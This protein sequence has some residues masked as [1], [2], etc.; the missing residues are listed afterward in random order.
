MSTFLVETALLF[1]DGH[2]A[3]ALVYGLGSLGAGLLLA[4]AGITAAR[5]TPQRHHREVS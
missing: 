4:Y 1:K 2:T 5:L 3:T